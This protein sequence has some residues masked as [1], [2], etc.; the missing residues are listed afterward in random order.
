M[1]TLTMTQ[2]AK[3]MEAS[4]KVAKTWFDTGRLRGWRNP[5]TGDRFTTMEHLNRFRR[6][7]GLPEI[8]ATIG[9]EIGETT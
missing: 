2:V 3:L 1:T 8:V 6:E 5:Q 7:H 4:L 9:A